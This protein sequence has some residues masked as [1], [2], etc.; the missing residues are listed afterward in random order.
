MLDK[1][2]ENTTKAA[3]ADLRAATDLTD[4]EQKILKQIRMEEKKIAPVIHKRKVVK[5]PNPLSMKKKSTS[6]EVKSE[7]KPAEERE[8]SK[9][10][11]KKRRVKLSA[12]AKMAVLAKMKELTAWFWKDLLYRNESSAHIKLLTY[13]F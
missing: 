9:K 1:P 11:S 7:A 12:H 5:G 8:S 10:K 2:S 3:E 4:H 13:D 6:N